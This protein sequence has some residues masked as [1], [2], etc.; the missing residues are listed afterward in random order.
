MIQH[1]VIH[2]VYHRGQIAT[3]L[4]QLNMKPPGLDYLIYIDEMD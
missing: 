4:R 2:S 1:M 3:M